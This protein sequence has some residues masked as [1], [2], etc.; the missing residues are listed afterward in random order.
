MFFRIFFLSISN[1]HPFN[2][3]CYNYTYEYIT[4]NLSHRMIFNLSVCINVDKYFKSIL[5]ISL[6]T[7][8]VVYM[9]GLFFF[10][11]SLYIF[12]PP[13]ERSTILENAVCARGLMQNDK[14]IY[15]LI[16]YFYFFE[17][18]KNCSTQSIYYRK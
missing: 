4:S 7:P 8:N 1:L 16:L 6:Y 14:T 15:L 18:M 5:S 10:S 17:Q 3:L 11:F 12:L 13:L 2:A 9:Y